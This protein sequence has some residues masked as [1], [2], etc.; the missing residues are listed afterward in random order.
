MRAKFKEYEEFHF[1]VRKE[2]EIRY[3]VLMPPKSLVLPS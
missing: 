1:W 2:V 3:S